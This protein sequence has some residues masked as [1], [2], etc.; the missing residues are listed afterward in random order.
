[1]GGPRR[2]WARL[3]G[4]SRAVQTGH[5]AISW[6]QMSWTGSRQ[7]DDVLRTVLN[8]NWQMTLSHPTASPSVAPRE[9]LGDGQAQPVPWAEGPPV[10]LLVVDDDP[11]VRAAIAQTV[12]G[13]DDLTLVGECSD[14][15]GAV[16]MAGNVFA[17]VALVDLLLPNRRIGLDLVRSLAGT[18]GCA[19]V[20]MSVRGGLRDDALAA[21]AFAFVEKGGD[22]D[23]VLT[24]VRAAAATC[25][26]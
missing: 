1:M 26:S 10:R 15:L 22:I 7:R 23:A 2:P 11:R 20:A 17:S 16:A 13:E 18:F 14:A 24:A 6:R 19:V 12:S 8:E 21:G 3:I 5:L 25:R 9:K 4:A